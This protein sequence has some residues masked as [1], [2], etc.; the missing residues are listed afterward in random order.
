MESIIPVLGLY[1]EKE[2]RDFLK[3]NKFEYASLGIKN[4]F[5]ML[6]VLKRLRKKYAKIRQGNLSTNSL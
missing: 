1:K 4:G 6:E 3:E 2:L 5:E